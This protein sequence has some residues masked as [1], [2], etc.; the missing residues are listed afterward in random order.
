MATQKEAE[1]AIYSAVAAA[2]K[3]SEKM[4]T[5]PRAKLLAAAGLAYRAAAGGEQVGGFSFG[6]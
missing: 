2:A 6:E 3:D 1:Q 4:G 5:L